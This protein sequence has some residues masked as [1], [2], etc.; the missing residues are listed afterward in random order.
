MRAYGFWV[1]PEFTGSKCG[2]GQFDLHTASEGRPDFPGMS[3]VGG[4][5]GVRRPLRFLA[6]K[7]DLDEQQ[8]AELVRILDEIKTE[9][10]QAAVDDRRTLSAFAD[11]VAGETFNQAR[12]DEGATLRKTSGDR[13]ASVITAALPRIH[14]LLRPDQ[15]EKLAYLI[16]S[17]ALSL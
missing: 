6:Y 7:L 12:A 1:R 9:R 2:F 14:T 16:R 3:F 13:L 10:A 17:G 8:V 11:A 4:A 5:F 15:R